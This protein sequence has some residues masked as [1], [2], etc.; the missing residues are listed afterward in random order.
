MRKH[1]PG[2]W[3]GRLRRAADPVH[4]GAERLGRSRPGRPRNLSTAERKNSGIRNAVHGLPQPS[5]VRHATSA[6]CSLIRSPPC[7]RSG[8]QPYPHSGRGSPCGV[9]SC[10]H[11]G[12]GREPFPLPAAREPVPQPARSQPQGRALRLPPPGGIRGVCRRQT[13]RLRLQH[14]GGGRL[15]RF[16]ESPFPLPALRTQ[17]ERPAGANRPQRSGE[18]PGAAA[19]RFTGSP[20]C[21]S[22]GRRLPVGSSF[23]VPVRHAV[24]AAS[25][26]G[27]MCR[28]PPRRP[29][30]PDRG[31]R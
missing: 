18:A 22:A 5:A 28:R 30:V 8:V 21:C 13:R 6:V 1:Q 12:R 27:R 10:P 19:R 24:P 9:R 3:R 16:A 23:D 14:P 4:S 20:P 17:S 25:P 29:P 31:C 11:S 26:Q 2:D 15:R 7:S